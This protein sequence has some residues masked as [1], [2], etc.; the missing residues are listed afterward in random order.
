MSDITYISESLTETLKE[1]ELQNVSIDILEAI[2]DSMLKDGLLKDI[3]ILGTLV[4]LTKASSN[5]RD[6]L[7][8]KKLIS[9]LAQLKDVPKEE[10][11]KQ[12]QKVQSD[13]TYRTKVGEKLL[14][15]IDKCEDSEKSELIA[16]LF[17]AFLEE[18]IDYNDFLRCVSS[19]DSIP[20]PDLF[21]FIKHP[22]YKID[23]KKGSTFISAG[24]VAIDQ[25]KPKI[26]E[27]SNRYS[28]KKEPT[29]KVENTNLT[30]SI[31]RIGNIIIK[32][33]Q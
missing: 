4:G 31:T 33:L 17:K 2:S 32:I 19:I 18:K 16:K 6:K 5:I 1:G 27:G 11:L 12:I 30:C 23:I 26:T 28:F 7:F 21:E 13:K 22:P 15:I 9:F 10:R 25:I 8:C 14:Y 24:L 20:M 3:P 29:Y